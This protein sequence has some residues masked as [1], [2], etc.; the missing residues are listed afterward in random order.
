M[1][2]NQAM[3]LGYDN[4]DTD[5]IIPKQFL[6]ITDKNNLGQYAFYEWRYESDGTKKDTILNKNDNK[7]YNILITKHNFGCGSSREH[8]AW[9]LADYG[10]DVIIASSFS[11]IF[12]RNWL[13]NMKLPII[14]TKDEIAEIMDSEIK[15]IEVD[16]SNKQ[17]IINDK[18]YHFDLSKKMQH[19]L[20]ENIDEIDYTMK[21]LDQI[22]K[23]ENLN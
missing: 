9:S 7:E 13:N 23:F 15:D 10:F 22:E 8:A 20:I 11:D 16:L 14:L 2:K 5:I 6:K 12:Y 17:V 21:Y 18:I 4:I 1:K 19:R 3:I